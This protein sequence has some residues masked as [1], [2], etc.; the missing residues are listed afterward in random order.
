MTHPES[1]PELSTAVVDTSVSPTVTRI[2]VVAAVVENDNINVRISGS[3]VLIEAAYL[4]PAYLPLLGDR[5]VVQRQDAAWFVL[6]TLS[7]PINTAIPN[8]SF[9]LN[10]AGVAP[11]N[12]T[13][14]VISSV[15]GVPTLLVSNNFGISGTHSADFGTDSIVAGTS[16]A[17]VFSAPVPASPESRWTA[18]TYVNVFTNPSFPDFSDLQLY[19]QFLDASSTLVTETLVASGSYSVD[20]IVPDYFR[21]NLGLVPAGFVICPPSASQARMRLRGIFRLPAT[22]FFSFFLDYMILRQ[23]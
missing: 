4:F 23:V 11:D 17:N 16:E 9:E 13:I 22:S 8:P 2:G 14:Q 3:D 10:P 20:Q 15:A 1:V 7:G 18:A 19:I 21:L 12:W 6:G 5:V